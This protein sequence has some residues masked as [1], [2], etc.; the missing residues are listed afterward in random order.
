MVV[1]IKHSHKKTQ[2]TQNFVYFV[3]L[4]GYSQIMGGGGHSPSTACL[5]N[6]RDHGI[7]PLSKREKSKVSVFMLNVRFY[8][9]FF[10]FTSPQLDWSLRIS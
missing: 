2:E 1:W 5:T 4:R 7:F 8:T 3:S 10:Y 6:C 9:Y